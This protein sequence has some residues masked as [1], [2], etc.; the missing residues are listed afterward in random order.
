MSPE[1]VYEVL[2]KVTDP[3]LGRNIVELG[4]VKDLSIEDGRIAF[5][6]ELTTPGCPLKDTLTAQCRQALLSAFPEVREVDI[7]VSARVRQ[8]ARIQERLSVPVKT[9]LAVGSGKGGVGKSTVTALLAHLFHRLGARVGVLDADIYGPN[10][11]RLLPPVQGPEAEGE[12]IVPGRTR[13]GIVVM[14]VGFLVEEGQALVWRGPMLHSMLQSL[15]T[16]VEWPALDYLLLDLPPG[17]GDVQLSASQ[18]LPLTG[19]LLVATPHPLAQEDLRRGVDAF[20]RLTVPL[21]GVI[22]NMAGEVW[23]EGL[24]A[25]T[26]ESLGVPFL[27]SIPLSREIAHAGVSGD[28]SFLDGGELPFRELV[29][30]VGSR[31]SVETYR[32]Q[33]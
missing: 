24:T 29:E 30:A 20:N 31:V 11:P 6:L 25:R 19:A 1:A 7:R 9:V 15:I 4:F 14:S 28:F 18:L 33:G 10:I 12:R 21:L 8:D 22:E 26:A 27:G 32:L 3:E 2:S 23:G 5:T 16:Q 13:E 17:T